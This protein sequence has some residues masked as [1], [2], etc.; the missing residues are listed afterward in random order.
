RIS[1]RNALSGRRSGLRAERARAFPGALLAKRRHELRHL[2]PGAAH[3]QGRRHPALSARLAGQLVRRRQRN[4][5]PDRQ[6]ASRNEVPL[7]S[8]VTAGLVPPPRFMWRSSAFLNEI[9]GTGPAMTNPRQLRKISPPNRR[10]GSAAQV[11]TTG[12]L[13]RSRETGPR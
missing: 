6:A 12:G 4:R 9:A 10:R 1:Q 11:Y 13:S 3:R 7:L 5:S 8:G 2:P